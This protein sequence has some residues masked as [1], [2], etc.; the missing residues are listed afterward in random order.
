MKQLVLELA[1]A[2]EPTLDNFVVGANAEVVAA[3]RG[4]LHGGQAE[5]FLYLWGGSG[6]GRSHLLQAMLRAFREDGRAVHL[7]GGSADGIRPDDACI[8]DDVQYLDGPAQVALFNVC[9]TLREGGGVLL[10]AGD[11]PPARLSLRP[12]LL[13]RLAWGLVYE[14]HALSESDRRAA[15]RDYAAARGF[16]LPPEVA[17]Y[18]LARAPR[19]LSSLRALVDTLDR[20]S[21]Q[22]KRAITVPLARELLQPARLNQS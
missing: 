13:T 14:V 21:L 4:L 22:Q 9:N 17:D 5:R 10:A 6:S 20:L 19:D 3:L 16:T 8:A 1:A 2:P 18:L 7:F 15:L 11:L 12:D